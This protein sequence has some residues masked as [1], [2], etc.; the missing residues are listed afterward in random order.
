MTMSTIHWNVQTFDEFKADEFFDVL[1]L[2]VNVFVVEQQCAYPELD[3]DD[4]HAETRHLQGYDERGAL[5]AYAR[6]LPAGLKY[7]EVSI[8]RF[9]VKKERRGQGIGH[10]L[11][12]KSLEVIQQCWSSHSI[13]IAAQEYLKDFYAQYGFTQVSERYLDAGVPHIE[14]LKES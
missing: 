14:M 6:L 8:G 1:Q 3:G 13:K 4:R 11:L 10:Q 5:V 2:R 7:A 9:V 12:R